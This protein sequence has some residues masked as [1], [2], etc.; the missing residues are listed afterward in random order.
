MGKSETISIKFIANL[1]QKYHRNCYL[2]KKETYYFT[3][4][5]KCKIILLNI[6]NN[7]KKEVS[8]TLA[9]IDPY[10]K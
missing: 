2:C 5:R 4:K 10:T 3:L 6:R 1:K 7:I 9:K 8:K